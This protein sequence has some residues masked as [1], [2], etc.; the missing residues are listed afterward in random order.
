MSMT[1]LLGKAASPILYG[2]RT[3]ARRWQ[4]Q[5]ENGQITVALCFHRVVADPAS[6]QRLFG[7]E[8]GIT[9][10]LFEAQIKFMLQ[11]FDAALPSQV[12]NGAERPRFIVTFDD[13]YRDNFNVAA[14][15]LKRLGVP[16]AF[17]VVSDFV[18]QNRRFWWERLACMLRGTPTMFLN[19][20]GKLE[21]LAQ[22][23][24]LPLR[25][26]LRDFSEREKAHDLISRALRQT[27]PVEID[28]LLTLL[29]ER[30]RIADPL[31]GRDYPL[32]DWE[33]IALLSASGFEIGAHSATHVN[34]GLC[35]AEQINREVTGSI[36]AIRERLK[37]PIPSFAYPYGE[38][39]QVGSLAPAA[40]K[41]AGCAV[42]FTTSSGAIRTVSDHYRLPRLQ[43]NNPW[44]FAW[45]R[46]VDRAMRVS[47]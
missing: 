26:E 9:A 3:Y 17:Y 16:A 32:M 30:L 1:A 31:H 36:Q 25:L 11:N 7:V 28:S 21:T 20:E 40:V 22:R 6:S 47:L 13:G 46:Q 8:R 37:H 43:L 39:E 15:I 34:L 5:A 33:H 18:G 41:A 27:P 45:A 12:M 35:D 23:A 10:K 38:P 19:L 42:A 4:R 24:N 29:A 14:P 2:S 44:S